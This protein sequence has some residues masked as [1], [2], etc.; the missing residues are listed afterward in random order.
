MS[1]PKFLVLISGSTSSFFSTSRGIRQGDPLSP[2]LFILMSEALSKIIQREV[3]KVNIMELRP[4]SQASSCSHQKFVDDTL[5]MGEGS[6]KEA[7][8]LKKTLDT[9]EQGTGQNISLAKNS[10]FFFNTLEHRKKNISLILGCKVG[11]LPDSYLGFPL[12]HGLALDSF[13]ANLIDRF[14]N[15]LAGWKGDLL[16]QDG[17]LQLLKASL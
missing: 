13:W 2:F 15:K 17:K 1:T 4:S 11:I 6:I 12:C 9:Y 7:K 8:I 5:L 14:Q 3:R 16:S 10:I